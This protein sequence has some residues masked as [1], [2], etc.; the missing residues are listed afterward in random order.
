MSENLSRARRLALLRGALLA[1][2]VLASAAVAAS[3]GLV[4]ELFA[5][6]YSG[7]NDPQ[8][9]APLAFPLSFVVLIVVG[10]P[11]TLACA[12]AWGGY[13]AV[14]RKSRRPSE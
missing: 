6:G 4:A 12:A 9:V 14:A 8:S 3:A 13:S 2:A 5:A 1:F 7:G 11:A 10:L